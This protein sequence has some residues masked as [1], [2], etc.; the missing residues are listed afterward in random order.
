MSTDASYIDIVISNQLKSNIANLSVINCDTINSNTKTIAP[1]IM[2]DNIVSS[3]SGTIN[4]NVP[5][6]NIGSSTSNVNIL[7]TAIN[8]KSTT[9]IVDN[10]LTLNKGGTSAIG[11]GFEIKNLSD[12]TVG[13]VLIDASGD[14]IMDSTNHTLNLTALNTFNPTTGLNSSVTNLNTYGE[15]TLNNPLYLNTGTVNG[16]TNTYA[17]FASFNS[18][19]PSKMFA[20]LRQIGPLASDGSNITLSLDLSGGT[21]FYINNVSNSITTPLFSI[22]NN[23]IG[24]S[25]NA[26][27]TTLDVSG[28]SILNGTTNIS[29]TLNANGSSNTIGSSSSNTHNF[30]NKLTFNANSTCILTYSTIPA[31]NFGALDGPII[32]SYSVT[33]A[34]VTGLTIAATSTGYYSNFGNLKL[35]WGN[36]V[37]TTTTG[38]TNSSYTGMTFSLPTSFLS[39][40]INV[41]LSLSIRTGTNYTANQNCSLVVTSISNTGITY[42]YFTTTVQTSKE[43]TINF[44][45]IGK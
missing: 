17:S 37:A 30:N 32:K 16:I 29:G 6:I 12:T 18:I 41:N 7:G 38:S 10:V 13:S 39:T 14:F 19:N 27:K 25:S 20:N 23:K 22:N 40:I 31:I 33:H 36:F 5:T 42:S 24:I 2:C 15:T 3:S 34:S 26:P 44:F 28:S 21:N 9:N 4:L 1:L 35:V 8:L 43:Q 45:I 11:S